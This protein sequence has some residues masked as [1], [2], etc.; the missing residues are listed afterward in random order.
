M[1]I[2]MP[3]S[4]SNWI[5]IIGAT[6]ALISL[7]LILFLFTI[8]TFLERGNSYLGLIIYLLLPAFMIVGLILIPVGMYITVRKQRKGAA[9]KEKRWPEIN[10]NN[11]AHRNGFIIFAAGT[12]IFLLI[13]AI[14]SYEAFHYTESVSFCGKV[15]HS[16]MKPEYTAYQHSPHARVACVDCHVGSGADWY[17]KSKLSGLYQVYAVTFGKVPRPIET[18]VTDLRPARETCEQCHWPQKFYDRKLRLQKIYLSDEKNTEWNI[19]YSL[20]VAGTHSSE[21]LNQGIHW[22]INPAVKIEY[23]A[24][25]RQRQVIPWVRYTDL[26]TKKVYIYEQQ[27]SPVEKSKLDSMETRVMDCIDCH[28]RPSHNYKPP[29][30]FVSNAITAGT[31]PR[32]LPEIKSLSM[33]ICSKKFSTT[34]SAMN[35]IKTEINRFYNEKYPELSKTQA[36]LIGQAIKGLKGEYSRNIFPEMKVRWDAYPNNIGHKEFPGCFRC[37]NDNHKSPEGRVISRDCQLCHL[38]YSQGKAENNQILPAG[39]PVEFMHPDG[40]ESWKEALCTECHTGLNP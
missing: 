15:C 14:G 32:N 38:I 28:N 18:P 21:G 29:A 4:A 25:D 2:R 6:I 9:V 1:K 11:P 5:S 20:K 17:V 34:D 12:A 36:N 16:V 33:D 35:Y 8:T 27:D 10:L 13:S 19:T 31:I 30:V 24:S 37:H 23:K 7:F 22:H 3:Y 40:D 39:G 26:K